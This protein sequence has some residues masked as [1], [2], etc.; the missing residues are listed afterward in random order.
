MCP[1]HPDEDVEVLFQTENRFGCL[2]CSN[3]NPELPLDNQ[4][5][6]AGEAL[7]LRSIIRVF[8]IGK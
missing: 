6:P 4:I 3:D 1:V 5:P 8:K 7:L 2:K